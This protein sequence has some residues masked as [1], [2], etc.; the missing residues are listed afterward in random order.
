MSRNGAFLRENVA[1]PCGRG[2]R[3]LEHVTEVAILAGVPRLCAL[4]P[5]ESVRPVR[6]P[7][8]EAASPCTATARGFNTAGVIPPT[9]D[10][11]EVR[12]RSD[13]QPAR[14]AALNSLRRTD[15]AR[16]HVDTVVVSRKPHP[17][18]PG[19]SAVVRMGV[20]PAAVGGGWEPVRGPWVLAT[21]VG[22]GQCACVGRF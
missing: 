3:P 4:S 13:P 8:K 21:I 18:R 19:T 6:H 14:D 15:G 2:H 5:A 22:E 10:L 11:D 12:F 17:D 20:I 16:C 1:I 9:I 7:R